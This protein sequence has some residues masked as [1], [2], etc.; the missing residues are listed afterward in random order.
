[1]SESERQNPSAQPGPEPA[2]I[3]SPA[4]AAG[5]QSSGKAAVVDGSAAAPATVACPEEQ[6]AAA[7]KEAAGNYDRYVRAIADLENFRRRVAREKEELRQFASASLLLNLLPVLDN[8]QLGVAAAR[9]QTDTKTIV[10]GVAMVLEQLKGVLSSQG[11]KEINPV[12]QKFDPHQHESISHQ[13]SPEVP[14]AHVLHVVRIGYSLNG[15]LLR[16]ASV[17]VSSGPGKKE[18]S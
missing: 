5:D 10:D 8:L 18:A 16:P 7:K 2:A 4:D 3:D 11:L 6:L 9:Q 17:V 1:M 14:E 12:G 15:R 13:P